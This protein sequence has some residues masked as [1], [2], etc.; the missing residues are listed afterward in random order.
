ML[1]NRKDYAYPHSI[2]F[3]V[4]NRDTLQTF[5]AELK[6]GYQALSARLRGKKAFELPEIY[7]LMKKY[8]RPFDYL[9]S[10]PAIPAKT[11]ARPPVGAA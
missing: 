1:N 7:E 9:F 4:E 10:I 6:M 11:R 5:S 8:D 3:M 2:A